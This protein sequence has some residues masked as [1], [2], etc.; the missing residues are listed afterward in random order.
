[1]S[2][3]EGFV[4]NVLSG[5]E[6][7]SKRTMRIDPSLSSP[8]EQSHS[9]TSAHLVSSLTIM[10]ADL[11][12]NVTL[13]SYLEKNFNAVWFLQFCAN[14]WCSPERLRLTITKAQNYMLQS[15]R[16][17]FIIARI[18][19]VVMFLM[20]FLFF[21]LKIVYGTSVSS[22]VLNV[23]VTLDILSVLPA[24]YL[25]QMRMLQPARIL[26]A[27]VIDESIRISTYYLW[28]CIAT[29]V[30]SAVMYTANP[31]VEEGATENTIFLVVGEF[32]IGVN[33]A[34]NMFF[35]IMDLKVSSLLLDQLFL[36]HERKQLTLDK[37]VMVREDI[38]RRVNLSKFASDF[39]AVPCLASIVTI[40][41]L[42]FH[43]DTENTLLSGAW[44]VVLTKE[45]MFICIAFWYVAHVNGRA[46]ELT[47]K[48]CTDTVLPPM[49]DSTVGLGEYL[50]KY[51]DVLKEIHR[52]SIYS[53]SVSSPISFTLLFKRVCWEDVIVSAVGFVIT[54]I[55]GLIESLVPQ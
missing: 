39:I 23:A 29:V 42:V 52:L 6:G 30:V 38:K 20:T 54:F 51:N 27:S 5:E 21:I 17:Y 47:A 12:T 49:L 40:L 37:F 16:V 46:D 32:Y 13:L 31:N 36:L 11:E 35:L 41:L 45:L 44:C 43:S 10:T 18:I 7:V 2:C 55:A 19:L 22:I 14:Y 24:Q 1:M 8:G 34:F 50:E 28:L 33:L 25:N 15:H 48:L 9:K 26:D 4:M 3:D 53:S